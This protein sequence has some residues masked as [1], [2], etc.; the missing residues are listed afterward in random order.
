MCSSNYQHART[1]SHGEQ[2]RIEKDTWD[3]KKMFYSLTSL[4]C[5]KNP[6][7]SSVFILSPQFM[8]TLTVLMEMKEYRAPTDMAEQKINRRE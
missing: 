5:M 3:W 6:S 1:Q 8:S 7:H 4:I 2:D